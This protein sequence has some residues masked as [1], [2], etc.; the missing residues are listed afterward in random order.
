MTSFALLSPF[1]MQVQYAIEPGP[2]AIPL[3][4]DG[5]CKNRTSVLQTLLDDASSKLK[6][7]V[8]V[9]QNFVKVFE[10]KPSDQD[11]QLEQY[12]G[13]IRHRELEEYTK[14]I[15]IQ[16][17]VG[18]VGESEV[19]ESTTKLLDF[20]PAD[21][22]LDKLHIRGNSVQHKLQPASSA[23]SVVG[24]LSLLN[25]NSVAADISNKH[26]AMN[27]TMKVMF[28]LPEV[29]E[30]R[31]LDSAF[32]LKLG[33]YISTLMKPNPVEL[34]DLDSR[35]VPFQDFEKLVVFPELTLET[36]RFHFLQVPSF[37]SEHQAR[38]A[39]D[40]FKAVFRAKAL[41][42]STS[43]S[44]WVYLDWHLSQV[45]HCNNH[46]CFHLHRRVMEDELR[47][48]LQ[49]DAI[50]GKRMPDHLLL[51]SLA[52]DS[53]PWHHTETKCSNKEEVY[54][55][56]Y[57]NASVSTSLL[58]FSSFLYTAA[59]A[60]DKNLSDQSVLTHELRNNLPS[61]R[62]QVSLAGSV[63]TCMDSV[64][65][66]MKQARQGEL[67]R[68]ANSMHVLLNESYQEVHS[69]TFNLSR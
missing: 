17:L 26:A 27:Y 41:P 28:E 16:N 67:S 55:A 14:T 13:Q 35:E 68:D 44:D 66:L 49:R 64:L 9:C 50:L 53:L 42:S 36:S 60:V 61:V 43:A 65:S 19:E 48:A 52:E 45:G 47:V 5:S 46:G 32:T 22:L 33:T 56:A 69:I 31:Y 6:N 37:I 30:D 18:R 11:L 62:D 38:I 25:E 15:D 2:Y 20:D 29:L 3:A 12:S 54:P 1:A 23:S 10:L 34:E 4:R 40:V 7:A 57:L 8:S 51:L 58:N 63:P 39:E 21:F 24:G 59:K